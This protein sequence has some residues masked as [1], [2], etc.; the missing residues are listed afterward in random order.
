ME[1]NVLNEPNV[2]ENATAQHEV[3]LTVPAV[4]EELCHLS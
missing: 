3:A 2:N 4:A 1:E